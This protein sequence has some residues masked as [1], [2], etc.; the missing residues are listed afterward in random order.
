MNEKF[1][2]YFKKEFKFLDRDSILYMDH[3]QTWDSAIR[4]FGK[5]AEIQAKDGNQ[6]QLKNLQ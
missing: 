5:D 1:D 6:K 4:H 3:K 2:E